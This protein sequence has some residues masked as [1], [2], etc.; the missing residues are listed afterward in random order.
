MRSIYW[1]RYAII[2][3][4][5]DSIYYSFNLW[6]YDITSKAFFGAHFSDF[7]M[8]RKN[9]LSQYNIFPKMINLE[10]SR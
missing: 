5:L 1:E 2:M 8:G 3:E 6:L 9:Y 7:I 10:T 4:K